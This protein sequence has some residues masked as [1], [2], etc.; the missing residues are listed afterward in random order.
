MTDAID[1]VELHGHAGSAGA[2]GDVSQNPILLRSLLTDAV[3]A[4]WGPARTV[5]QETQKPNANS[6]A[7]IPIRSVLATSQARSKTTRRPNQARMRK[8]AGTAST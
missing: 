5:V 8:I 1:L 3:S 7:S 6:F 2:I 4:P